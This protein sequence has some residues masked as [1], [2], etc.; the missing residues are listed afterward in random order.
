M[1]RQR[2]IIQ[3]IQQSVLS[4]ALRVFLSIGELETDNSDFNQIAYE[5]VVQVRQTL[6][7][8]G[9]PESRIR[10]DFI[11]G[12][13]HHESTWSPLFPEAHRWLLQP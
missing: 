3:L 12:G 7:A 11:T 10:F 13:T 1:A 4:P 5:H 2:P 8:A 6:I 9:V